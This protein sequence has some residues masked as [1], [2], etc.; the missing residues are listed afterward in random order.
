MRPPA[1]AQ[2]QSAAVSVAGGAVAAVERPGPGDGAGARGGRGWRDASTGAAAIATFI[3]ELPGLR[4]AWVKV[5]ADVTTY[6]TA[7]DEGRGIRL[8]DGS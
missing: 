8:R 1:D 4:V 2:R 7:T 5:E 6:G 3:A